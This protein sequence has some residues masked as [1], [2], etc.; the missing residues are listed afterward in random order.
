[1]CGSAQNVANHA[2]HISIST[3]VV[4]DGFDAELALDDDRCWKRCHTAAVDRAIEVEPE[5]PL[6]LL[7]RAD[8]RGGTGQYEEGIADAERVLAMDPRSRSAYVTLLNFHGNRGDADAVRAVL[9]R[10]EEMA[11]DYSDPEEIAEVLG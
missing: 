2:E 6:H 10:L 11:R 9:D 3:A 5:N 8:F 4:R 7:H 1:M